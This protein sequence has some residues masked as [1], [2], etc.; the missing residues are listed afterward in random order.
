MNACDGLSNFRG[1]WVRLTK[2]KCVKMSEKSV[3]WPC[4]R[5]VGLM[6]DAVEKDAREEEEEEGRLW[7]LR[8]EVDAGDK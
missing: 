7:G 2:C 5:G 4:E 3:P 1:L 6:S 8:F